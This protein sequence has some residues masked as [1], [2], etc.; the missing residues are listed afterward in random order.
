ML[1]M[2]GEDAVRIGNSAFVT[3]AAVAKAKQGT[4]WLTESFLPA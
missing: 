2:L 4:T 1:S 3:A